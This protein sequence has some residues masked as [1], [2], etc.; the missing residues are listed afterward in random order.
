MAIDSQLITQFSD[1][2]HIGIEES[3]PFLENWGFTKGIFCFYF[4]NIHISLAI[5][6]THMKLL[7]HIENIKM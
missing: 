6:G 5:S 2:N 3:T 1:I 7:E 4:L